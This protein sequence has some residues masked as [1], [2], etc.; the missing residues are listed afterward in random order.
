MIYSLIHLLIDV[1][2]VKNGLY[3]GLNGLNGLMDY[4]N[5]SKKLMKKIH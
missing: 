3:N 2:P 4:S 1:I 5:Y